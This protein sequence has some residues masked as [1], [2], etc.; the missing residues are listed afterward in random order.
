MPIKTG[1]AVAEERSSLRCAWAGCGEPPL[2]AAVLCGV[3]AAAVIA[4]PL[5][6][7]VSFLEMLPFTMN[8]SIAGNAL[9]HAVHTAVHIGMFNRYLGH[10]L[11]RVAAASRDGTGVE[12]TIAKMVTSIRPSDQG[13][14][15][16]HLKRQLLVPERRS[17]RRE[18]PDS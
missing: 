1:C 17:V 7:F 3:H 18:M 10:D 4:E 15:I 14:F 2:S 6:N 16:M 8:I 9:Y 12:T 13:E 5:S 11:M